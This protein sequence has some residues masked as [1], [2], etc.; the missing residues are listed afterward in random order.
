MRTL[1]RGVVTDGDA[2]DMEVYGFRIIISDRTRTRGRPRLTIVARL[3]SRP[4]KKAG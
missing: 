3:T 4:S 2:L 1:F